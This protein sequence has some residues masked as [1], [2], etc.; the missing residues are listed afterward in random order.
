MVGAIAAI[1]ILIMFTGFFCGHFRKLQ[2]FYQAVHSS[3][4]DS[5]AIVTLQYIGDFI[6][7]KPLIIISVN[8]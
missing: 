8:L 2:V 5:N 1:W 3:D 7:T 6:G 4:A